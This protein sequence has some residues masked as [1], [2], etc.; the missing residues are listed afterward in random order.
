MLTANAAMLE[1]SWSRQTMTKGLER[2]FV[3]LLHGLVVTVRR[4]LFFSAMLPSDGV[5]DG[6]LKNLDLVSAVKRL[7]CF[8]LSLSLSVVR[9]VLNAVHT[10]AIRVI[11][12]VLGTYVHVAQASYLIVVH[13]ISPRVVCNTM[14]ASLHVTRLANSDAQSRSSNTSTNLKRI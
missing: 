4:M 13:S 7:R 11:H 8:S 6:A 5:R 3:K 10:A 12:Q 9:S 2:L 1:R 14:T